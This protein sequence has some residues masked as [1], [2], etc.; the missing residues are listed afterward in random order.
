MNSAPPDTAWS[1]DLLGLTLL[2]GCLFFFLLG[3]APL[4][5]P[6]EGRYAE[7]PREMV[8]SGDWVTPRLD[9]VKYFEKPPLGYWV[10]AASIEILGPSEWS[11]RAAPALFGLAGVLITYATARRLHG[12][13]AGL[14]AA[15]VLGSSAFYAALARFLN[16]DIAVSVLI[17]GT[18]CAFLLAVGEPPGARR[19]RLFYA[20]YAGAALATLT[21][22]LI[23]FLLPGAVM[24]LW[25]ALCQQWRRLRPLYLPSGILLFLAIAAPWHLLVAARNPGWAR[26]YFGDQQWSRFTTTALGRYHPWYY[27]IPILLG[28]LFPWLGFLG[29][30]IGAALR[31]GWAA[32]RE[33]ASRWFWAIWAAFIFLFFSSSDSKLATYILPVFPPLAV[34]IGLVAAPAWQANAIAPIRGAVRVFAACS[35]LIAIAVL[36][37]VTIPGRFQIEAE[38]I[39]S[40]R[41]FA[42]ALAAVLAGGAAAGLWAAARADVRAALAAIVATAFLFIGILA[43]ITGEFFHPSTRAVARWAKENLRPGDRIFFYADFYHDFL[44][45]SQLRVDGVGVHTDEVELVNDPPE[46][47]RFIEKPEFLREWAK[48]GRIFVLGQKSNEFVEQLRTDPTFHYH[49]PVQSRDFYLFSNQP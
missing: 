34:L 30:G 13:A 41:P 33:N 49:L 17:S 7:I 29:A 9:G 32:R 40:A 18:L 47:P 19:R 3:R 28:G 43:P 15:I 48:P 4:D 5:N 8:A 12:R 10:V 35:F 31:G 37:A 45:Y 24:L 2:F 42:F 25:L 21:K 6:D 27:F 20:V 16:I 1:R 46:R 22:G 39:E 11:V 38:R 36:T 26:F 23:G 14:A 44:Y